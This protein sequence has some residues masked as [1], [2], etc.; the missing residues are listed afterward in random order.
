MYGRTMT[1]EIVFATERT[2]AATVW[3]HIL[4]YSLWVMSVHMRFQ[5]E[6]TRKR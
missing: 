1:L 3:A 6:R 4:L 2:L 5:V